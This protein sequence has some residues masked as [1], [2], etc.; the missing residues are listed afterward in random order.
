VVKVIEKSPNRPDVVAALVFNSAAHEATHHLGYGNHNESFVAERQALADYNVDLLPLLS[1]VTSKLLGMKPAKLTPQKPKAPRAP[2]AQKITLSYGY[3]LYEDRGKLKKQIY[4]AL[5]PRQ[6]LDGFVLDEY[7]WSPSSP[8]PDR[9][10][11]LDVYDRPTRDPESGDRLGNV[12]IGWYELSFDPADGER[13]EKRWSGDSDALTNE[14][15][16][17]PVDLAKPSVAFLLAEIK[18]AKKALAKRR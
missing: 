13:T 7:D 8:N 1:A 2:K 15:S 16:G 5:E 18:K 4:A 12:S 3:Y 9:T 10:Y 11:S 14:P 6:K 17:T